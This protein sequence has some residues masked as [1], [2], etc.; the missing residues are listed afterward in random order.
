MTQT[1][2]KPKREPLQSVDEMLI[3]RKLL[4]YGYEIMGIQGLDHSF[5][6]YDK[7][8]R[9]VGTIRNGQ[10][11]WMCSV[12]GKQVLLTVQIMAESLYHVAPT[13]GKVLVRKL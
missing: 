13:G 5:W 8:N 11:R 6:I 4:K 10:L 7:T 2:V 3:I 9:N 12:K 1:Q